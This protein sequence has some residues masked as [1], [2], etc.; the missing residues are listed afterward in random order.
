MRLEGN[1]TSKRESTFENS[2]EFEVNGDDEFERSDVF[3]MIGDWIATFPLQIFY[4]KTGNVCTHTTSNRIDKFLLKFNHDEHYF[5][6][7]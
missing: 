4:F 5:L 3:L 1:S 6:F 2:H 7:Y